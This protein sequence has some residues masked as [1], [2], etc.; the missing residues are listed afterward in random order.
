VFAYERVFLCVCVRACVCACLQTNGKT[1]SDTLDLFYKKAR[2]QGD[3]DSLRKELRESQLTTFKQEAKRRQAVLRRLQH[4]DEHGTVLLKGRAACEIDTADELLTTE[5]MFNGVFNGLDKHQLVALASCLVPVEKSNEQIQLKT[6]LAVPLGDL[7]RTAR[8]IAEISN[9]EKIEV[10][11]EDFVESFK[12]SLMDVIY[13]WSKGAS[14]Q[15]ICDMTDIFEGSVIRATRRL[16]ELM[17]QLENAAR[18]IG[19]EEL[20]A[21]FSESAET[22]RRDIMFAASL[23]V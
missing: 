7:Q 1:G 20:A 19:D 6:D 10:E 2:L 11:V 5:L 3:A 16:D 15:K 14:F 9:E 18:A 21:K 13:N 4:V 22:V 8:F 23:Y 17:R 12:P